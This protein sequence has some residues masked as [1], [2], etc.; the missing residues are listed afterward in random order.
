MAQCA[1]QEILTNSG[2][3]VGKHPSWGRHFSA[4]TAIFPTSSATANVVV[5][6]ISPQSFVYVL[7]QEAGDRKLI[8][9][10]TGRKYSPME[11]VVGTVNASSST[12]ARDFSWFVCNP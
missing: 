6:Y 11:F 10:E 7:N 2:G 3:S 1:G 5:P 8:E 9:I 12:S 4:G